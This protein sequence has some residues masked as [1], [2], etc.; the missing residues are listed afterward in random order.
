MTL[1]E[2]AASQGA[3]DQPARICYKANTHRDDLPTHTHGLVAGITEEVPI[4]G[5]GFPMVLVSP[6]SI[7]TLKKK[8]KSPNLISDP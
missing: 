3:P 5:N 4:D 7:I 2:T 6:A 1:L 8:K